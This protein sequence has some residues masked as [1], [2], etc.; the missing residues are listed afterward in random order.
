LAWSSNRVE[1]VI[2]RFVT[3]PVTF[4]GRPQAA[5][6]AVCVCALLS[7]ATAPSA[8]SH[9]MLTMSVPAEGQ[10]VDT[11]PKS[12]ELRFRQ[13]VSVLRLRLVSQ[14][15]EIT[16]LVSVERAK[17]TLTI[18]APSKLA[19]G[20]HLLVWRVAG[21]DGH[22]TGGVVTFS[23]GETSETPELPILH[24]PGLS[25]AIW[26]VRLL[27]YLC[28]F[29]GVGGVFFRAW[30]VGMKTL[31]RLARRSI[32]L[33]LTSIIPLMIANVALRGLDSLEASWGAWAN[34]TVWRVGVSGTF[35]FGTALAALAAITAIVGMRTRRFSS[36][37][38]VALLGLLLAGAAIAATGHSRP[39]SVTGS[40]A[41]IL[42]FVHAICIIFWV[43]ALVPLAA[44]L[45]SSR[46]DRR[47]VLERFSSAIP[48]P[49]TALI[50]SGVTLSAL[51][52][53]SFGNLLTT[54]YGFI[55]SAK[56]ILV[57]GLLGLA[58]YNRFRLTPRFSR[59]PTRTGHSFSTFI[60]LELSV[61]VAI[62]GVLAL[63]RFEPPPAESRQPE[64][65]TVAYLQDQGVTAL[66]T[67]SPAADLARSMLINLVG[68]DSRPL[69]ADEVWVTAT[70]IAA[71]VQP[72]RRP[73]K[74]VGEGKWS[75]EGLVMPYAGVWRIHLDVRQPNMPSLQFDKEIVLGG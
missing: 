2:S 49:L 36:A 34:A 13:P 21:G 70:Q 14:G 5:L 64:L 18:P 3:S 20:T 68:S 32:T 6:V 22:P 26:A 35:G 38:V 4:P 50:V 19:S 28:L 45:P 40:F 56:V 11:A 58:A 48:L 69:E 33:S 54:N 46:T 30:I 41:R 27:I 9:A 25:Q 24:A 65:P 1:I 15:N 67:I 55:L 31:P 59:E 7:L 72:V 74:S 71:T 39:D 44:L 10:I 23:V 47:D 63:W 16:E 52:L 62:L 37:R 8:F 73:A 12:F 51:Q 57:L 61:V 43:G 66:L 60:G 75:L 53:G 42:L 29:I 17:E